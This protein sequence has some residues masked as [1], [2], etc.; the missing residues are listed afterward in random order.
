MNEI[1]TYKAMLSTGA[2]AGLPMIGKYKAAQILWVVYAYGGA[3]EEF[4][5]SPKFLAEMEYIQKVYGI[6]GGET[7]NAEVAAYLQMLKEDNSE[8]V[9]PQWANDLCKERWGFTLTNV[10]KNEINK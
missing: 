5:Y 3:R 4:T 6:D 2:A 8:D 7:P 9:I 10:S 1:E